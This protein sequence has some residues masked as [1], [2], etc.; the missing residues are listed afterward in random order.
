[1]V[2]STPTAVDQP[3]AQ[4]ESQLTTE[5]PRLG[6]V[7]WFHEVVGLQN[8]GIDPIKDL[9]HVTNEDLLVIFEE[10]VQYKGYSYL[11]CRHGLTGINELMQS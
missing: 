9:N 1:M 5:N 4:A 11:K 8:W 3:E 10:K 6:S 7:H 2:A